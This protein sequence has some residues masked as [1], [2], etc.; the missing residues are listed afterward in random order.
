MVDSCIYP[1]NDILIDAVF[2]VTRVA[3]GVEKLAVVGFV[4]RKEQFRCSFTVEPTGTVVIMIKLDRRDFRCAVAT[5]SWPACI[6]SP[7]P[8]V[9]KPHGWQKMQFSGVRAAVDC[10]DADYNVIRCCLG[11][12][13]ENVEVTVLVKNAGID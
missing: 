12:F 1:M 3:L 5:E 9:A 4:L 6:Q 10:F 11:I 13:D 7:A 8:G 2:H